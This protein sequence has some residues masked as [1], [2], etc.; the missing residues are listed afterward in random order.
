MSDII[1]EQNNPV[2]KAQ[3]VVI[4]GF[5]GE[6]YP[7]LKTKEDG[8]VYVEIT[9]E[10]SSIATADNQTS[11]DQKTKI[12]TS[13][14]TVVDTFGTPD[15]ATETTLAKLV[16]KPGVTYTWNGDYLQTK[17]SVFSDRTETTTYTW[18]DGK[19]TNKETIIT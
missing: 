11:G 5:D 14:G 6:S 8:T 15:G 2:A 19:L 17:V 7:A 1:N 12:V 16:E 10:L 18:T 13:T 9:D 4:K 3:E